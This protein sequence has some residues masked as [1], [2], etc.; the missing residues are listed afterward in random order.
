VAYLDAVAQHL[1]SRGQTAVA[2]G[3]VEYAAVLMDRGVPVLF[4]PE[5]FA[6]V[7]GL[8]WLELVDLLANREA[9]YSTFRIAKRGGGSRVIQA[10]SRTLKW[11]QRY[12]RR[13]ITSQMTV[14]DNAHGFRIGRSIIT[15]AEPHVGTRLVVRYDLKDFFGS[16]KE[17]R[18][19]GLF[20]GIGYAPA[21]A[22]I[23]TEVTTLRGALPQGAPTS[24]DLANRA[25]LRLDRRLQGLAVERGF[26]YTRYA[27]DLTFSGG[28]IRD[29]HA[30]RAIEFIIRDA[31]FAPNEQ[32]SALLSRA[33]RQ[34]VTGLVVN[35]KV[36]W[37]RDTRRW[38]R[39]E[40]YYL[41]KWGA[42]SHAVRRGY[43]RA[44]YREFIYGH[45]FALFSVLPDEA[46]A[47]LERLDQVT[48]SEG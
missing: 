25:A 29:A 40:I 43:K 38:L 12:V 4:S 9:A 24:P 20:R 21:V 3:H 11:V 16:I 22:A 6:H 39:Q 18:V 10:P 28:G 2:A 35:D 45:V 37:P 15:N 34:R 19:Q 1:A 36:N 27:D 33:T 30:R 8:S 47:Y 26:V 14:S 5:H 13:Y 31:G 48:W 42:A 46:V 23:L 7:V 32:K 17:E 41:E 44:R